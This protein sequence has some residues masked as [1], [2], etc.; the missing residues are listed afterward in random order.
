MTN[1]Q[2]IKPEETRG[3]RMGL[4]NLMRKENSKWWRTSRWWKQTLTWVVIIDIMVAFMLLVI[5]GIAR[6]SGQEMSVTDAVGNA[7]NLLF[8]LAPIAIT[9]GV[10]IATQDEVISEKES[11]TAAWVLSKPASRSAFLLSKLFSNGIAILVVMVFAPAFVAYLLF[12]SQSPDLSVPN[13]LFAVAIL[14]LH[15]LFYLC[16]SLAVGVVSDKRSTV[17]AVSLAV[18]LGGQ[19]VGF[20]IKPIATATPVGIL[21]NSIMPELMMFGTAKL[22]AADFMPVFSTVVWIVVLTVFS[23]NKIQKT[24]F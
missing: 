14:A 1:I 18:M 19:A 7:A 16:L 6:Q 12:I 10:I 8:G 20:F 17:L 4:K 2:S 21:V 23:L 24:E 9:L 3:W 11:G 15:T 5:P 13:Y 22:T